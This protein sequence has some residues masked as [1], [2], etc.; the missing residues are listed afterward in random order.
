MINFNL[1]EQKHGLTT[2]N[3]NEGFYQTLQFFHF[4][5]KTQ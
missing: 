5:K 2:E 1:H 3:L 4:S